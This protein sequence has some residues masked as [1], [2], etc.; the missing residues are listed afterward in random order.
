MLKS[1][2][3]DHVIK[4]YCDDQVAQANHDVLWR[5]QRDLD[6]YRLEL[7]PPEPMALRLRT[8]LENFGE[9]IRTIFENALARDDRKPPLPPNAPPASPGGP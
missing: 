3:R 4:R 6:P 1:D 2:Q 7:E 5:N 8:G 9:L